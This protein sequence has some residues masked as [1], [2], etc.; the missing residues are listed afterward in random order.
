LRPKSDIART[1]RTGESRKWEK[2]RKNSRAN[3]STSRRTK[4][5]LGIGEGGG[6][7]D[8]IVGSGIYSKGGRAETTTDH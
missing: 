2:G 1:K 6:R 4:H 8:K 5:T 7:V 3:V